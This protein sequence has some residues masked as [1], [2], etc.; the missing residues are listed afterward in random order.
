M[1][2][3]DDRFECFADPC[4]LW[5]VWDRLWEVPAR[6]SGIDL[7][8]LTQSEAALRCR[9]MN[10]DHAG[11]FVSIEELASLLKRHRP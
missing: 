9:M 11:S 5:T 10:A 1:V 3:V 7:V 2:A 4:D 8:G 6:A